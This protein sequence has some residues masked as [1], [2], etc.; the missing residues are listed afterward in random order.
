M[1]REK[2]ISNA[3]FKWFA[4]WAMRYALLWHSEVMPVF[5]AC[6]V[7]TPVSS[8]LFVE[9]YVSIGGVCAG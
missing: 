8:M 1:K 7:V 4:L 2:M 3:C 9:L 5:V 6:C